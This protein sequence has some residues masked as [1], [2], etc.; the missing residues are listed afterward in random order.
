MNLSVIVLKSWYE[1]N[2][3]LYN[4][5]KFLNCN[6]YF[7]LISV[8]EFDW[9]LLN[10]SSA[11][12]YVLHLYDDQYVISIRSVLYII[13]TFFKQQR[14]CEAECYSYIL[15]ILTLYVLCSD[16]YEILVDI[17]PADA[18][19]MCIAR[20]SAGMI[21]T[22]KLLQWLCININIMHYYKSEACI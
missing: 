2:Y 17:M 12:L 8:H 4:C 22:I 6:L 20:A 9:S 19:A 1:F 14:Q 10:H 21:L 3:A 7:F 18:L 11:C 16:L 13:I 5:Y 15:I